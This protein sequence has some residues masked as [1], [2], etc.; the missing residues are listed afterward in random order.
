M[1]M[2]CIPKILLFSLVLL[3]SAPVNELNSDYTSMQLFSPVCDFQR[4]KGCGRMAGSFSW[5][6]SGAQLPQSWSMGR[7]TVRLVKGKTL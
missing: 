4:R 2:V 7:R 6:L 1:A 5:E 3:Y